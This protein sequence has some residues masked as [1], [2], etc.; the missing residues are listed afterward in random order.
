MTMPVA[1]RFGGV[2]T[3]WQVSAIDGSTLCF[4]IGLWNERDEILKECRFRETNLEGNHGE[5]V[6]E[7]WWHLNSTPTHSW[8]QWLYKYPQRRPNRSE[9]SQDRAHRARGPRIALRA[10]PALVDRCR[11]GAGTRLGG[12]VRRIR[13]RVN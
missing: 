12:S 9:L 1:A 5:D 10:V 3:G 6:K 2:K 11:A 7:E 8:M 4:A 13:R